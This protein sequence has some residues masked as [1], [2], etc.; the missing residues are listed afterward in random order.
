M[1][2][3]KERNHICLCT[4]DIQIKYSESSAQLII[5]LTTV[6]TTYTIYFNQHLLHY[7]RGYIEPIHS[8]KGVKIETKYL[9]IT[10]E[11]SKYI[12]CK[13]F[14]FSRVVYIFFPPFTFFDIKGSCILSLNLGFRIIQ[15]GME[16]QCKEK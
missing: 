2:N 1:I 7:Q 15:L 16:S 13:E 5:L 14:C 3:Q 4:V 10:Q 6:I 11:R 9:S 8:G 12:V